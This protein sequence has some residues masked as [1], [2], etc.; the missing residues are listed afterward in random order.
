[1]SNKEYKIC[2]K[3]KKKKKSGNSDENNN[4]NGFKV[5]DK[6]DR[7]SFIDRRS[8]TKN[9]LSIN[10]A[11]QKSNIMDNTLFSKSEIF[12]NVIVD[13]SSESNYLNNDIL[14]VTKSLTKKKSLYNDNLSKQQSIFNSILTKSH[15]SKNNNSNYSKN[16]TYMFNNKL[17]PL[18]TYKHSDKSLDNKLESIKISRNTPNNNNLSS[19]FF[20][21]Y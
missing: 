6:I 4:V 2:S 13:K 16:S 1:M 15:L 3:R 10:I 20:T 14:K 8:L 18:K 17:T 7:K 19:I 21:K 5:Q 11:S 9:N 12:E